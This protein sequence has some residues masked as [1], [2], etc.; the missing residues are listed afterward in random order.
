MR[1]TVVFVL[2]ASAFV[3]GG[4]DMFRKMAG[5][6][7]SDEIERRKVEISRRQAEIEA[8]KIEQKQV[9]D[10]LAML[11]SLR[12]MCDKVKHLSD[13]GDLYTVDLEARYYIIVG[14]FRKAGNAETMIR[15]ASGAGYVPVLISF[16]NGLQAVGV[17]PTD[18]LSDALLSLKA[19]KREDFCPPDVWVLVN[20]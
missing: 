7:T 5:R 6:P 8:M 14:S 16:R 4:C 17:S 11:D 13:I 1:R 18:R 12:S 20:R 15:K 19:V 10:S 9:A 3:F 2:L